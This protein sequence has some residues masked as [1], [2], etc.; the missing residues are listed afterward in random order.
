VSAHSARRAW[1]PAV[2]VTAVLVVVYVLFGLATLTVI[3]SVWVDEAWYT[4]PAWSFVTQGTFA[5]PMFDDLAGVDQDNVVMGRVY[6]LL[7]AIAFWV[8]DVSVAAVRM[9]SFVSGLVAV[10]AVFGIGW[11]LWHRRVGV[12]AAVLLSLAPNFVRQSHDARPEVMLV[13]FWTTALYLVLSGDRTAS[14]WRLVAGGLVAGL[15]ADTHLNGVIFP[16]ALFVVLLVRRTTLRKLVL[17]S[18]GVVFAGTWWVWLH[19]LQDPGLFREQLEIFSVPMPV[20]EVLERP[21]QVFAIEIARYLL[22]QPRASI[23]MAWVAVLAAIVLLRHHCD[24]SLLSLLA[25]FG[26]VFLFMALFVGTRSPGY[27]VLLWPVGALLVA[28]LVDVSP[29]RAAV[30]LMGGLIIVSI[31][32]TGW[33]TWKQLQSSYDGHIARL[34]EQV[35]PNATVQAD[36]FLWFG[37]AD[38]PF[39]ASHYFVLA[40]SYEV[41][42]RRLGIDY[43]ILDLPQ[44]GTCAWCTSY[45][46]EVT[47]FLEEHAELIAE[48]HDP[49]YGGFIAPDGDGFVSQVYRV[50]D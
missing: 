11:E 40:E 14:P 28:R 8:G 18:L 49:L 5:L 24:R 21:V 22:V 15:A 38:Q 12:L 37:F 32:A 39:L 50:T 43:V 29:R 47:D 31:A 26:T 45:S 34:Q 23:L 2:A 25:L 10:V 48:L 20:F 46:G 4:Q 6:L 42:A 9:V 1:L 17:Y 7:M 33:D 16:V 30:G 19:I 44:I 27:A 35:P 3:P 41:N 36:P 13:A